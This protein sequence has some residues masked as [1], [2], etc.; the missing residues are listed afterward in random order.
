[1]EEEI[2]KLKNRLSAAKGQQTAMLKDKNIESKITL[3]NNQ[4]KQ[5][6]YVQKITKRIEELKE[7]NEQLKIKIKVEN[8]RKRK[9]NGKTE[10]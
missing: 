7:E 8:N 3:L 6:E 4:D 9:E 5:D 2:N 10:N 1:L